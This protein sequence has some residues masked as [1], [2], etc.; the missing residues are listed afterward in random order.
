M[1]IQKA[2]RDG[3]SHMSVLV[4]SRSG[5]CRSVAAAEMLKNMLE[6]EEGVSVDAPVHL[7]DYPA[8]RRRHV[9]CQRRGHQFTQCT[10][11][12]TEN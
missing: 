9:R 2:F 1:A 8:R 5:L 6:Q 3:K 10:T 7:C 12:V 11:E 4:Y